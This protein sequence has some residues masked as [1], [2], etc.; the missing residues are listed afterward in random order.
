MTAPWQRALKNDCPSRSDLAVDRA[1]AA[2]VFTRDV[3]DRATGLNQLEALFGG[4]QCVLSMYAP[5]FVSAQES[6]SFV[7]NV[8]RHLVRCAIAEW[9]TFL[10]WKDYSSDGVGSV[11][12]LPHAAR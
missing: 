9:K 6:L 10:G 11:E 5:Y 7:F 4:W 2:S 3:G 12:Q 8:S 1:H